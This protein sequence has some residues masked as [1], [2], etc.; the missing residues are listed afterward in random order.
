LEPGTYCGYGNQNDFT[1]DKIFI[2]YKEDWGEIISH[3]N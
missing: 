1:E 3:F 2:E